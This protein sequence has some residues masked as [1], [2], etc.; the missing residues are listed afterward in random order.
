MTRFL[1]D[2]EIQDVVSYVTD[3]PPFVQYYTSQLQTVV[4]DPRIIPKLKTALKEKHDESLVQPGE[5]V[6]IICAQSIGEKFTQSTLNTFHHAGLGMSGA[7]KGIRSTCSGI[8][9]R[10]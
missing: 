3:S 4:V 6:G 7:S 5:N 9:K 8:I 1:S 10:F 2:E